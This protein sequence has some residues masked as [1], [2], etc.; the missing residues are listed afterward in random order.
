MVAVTEVRRLD[1][2]KKPETMNGNAEA[3]WHFM[4]FLHQEVR[5][6]RGLTLRLFLTNLAIVGVAATVAVTGIGILIKW[7]N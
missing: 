6:V 7:L 5:D 2:P 3:I 4:E 1:H